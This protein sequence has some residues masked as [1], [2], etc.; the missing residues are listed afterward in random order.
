MLEIISI[1]KNFKNIRA[2]DG[3]SFAVSKGDIFGL[4]GPNGAGK[5]TTISMIATLLAPDEGRI[6]YKGEDILKS[7]KGIQ[8]HLGL[9]P[10]EIALYPSLSGMEN[11]QFWGK[12]YGLQG[13]ALKKRIDEVSDVIGISDRLKDKVQKYSGGMKRRLNIGAALLHEPELIIMDEPTVG[14]DPQ[15]RNHILDTVKSLAKKGATIIYTSHYMEE[16]EMLCNRICIMDKGRIIASGTRE[17]IT[18]SLGGQYEMTIKLGREDAALLGALKALPCVKKAGA[19]GTEILLVADAD[20]QST[21]TVLAAV[22]KSNAG[23][24]SFDVK[25]PSLETVFLNLT[26]RALR[27]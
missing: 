23:L 13:A 19:E 5:S 7:P 11:L 14:I 17:E 3:I 2:V 9:V 25:W 21:R 1:T 22:Q 26:G 12:A 20:E 18:E 10:Q 27:D 6:L 4:L 24:V 8:R 16:V 15:S